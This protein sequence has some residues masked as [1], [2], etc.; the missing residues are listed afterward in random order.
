MSIGY[1]IF[2]GTCFVIL[3]PVGLVFIVLGSAVYATVAMAVASH[4]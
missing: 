3:I 4:R 1:R 2:L